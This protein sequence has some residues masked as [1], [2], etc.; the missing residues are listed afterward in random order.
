MR[1]WA[2]KQ[3]GWLQKD[4]AAAMGVRTSAV[5]PWGTRAGAQG[6]KALAHRPPPGLAPRPSA[7][8]CAHLPAR[9]ARGAPADGFRGEVWT[10]K[11]VAQVIE[12][13][14]GV[15]SHPAHVSRRLRACGWS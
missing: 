4:I 14:F 8:Q 15:S 9:L 10:A 12:R 7:E 6:V 2:L 11:R 5:S 13:T 1:A 3:Q